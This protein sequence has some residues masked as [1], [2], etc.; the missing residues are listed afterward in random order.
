MDGVHVQ[1]KP[2]HFLFSLSTCVYLRKWQNLRH[3]QWRYP[4]KQN[5]YMIAF[6]R[7]APTCACKSGAEVLVEM[8]EQNK[9]ICAVKKWNVLNFVQK[10][11]GEVSLLSGLFSKC[12]KCCH[13]SNKFE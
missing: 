5:D 11:E 2:Q 6:R 3:M 1:C 9:L 8:V 13:L 4:V 12:F 10:D 7:M